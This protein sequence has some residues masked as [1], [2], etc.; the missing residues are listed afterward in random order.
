[1][2][3]AFTAA[4]ASFVILPLSLQSLPRQHQA[5][6]TRRSDGLLSAVSLPCV[7]RAR[8]IVCSDANSDAFE[9]ARAIE[10]SK[11]VTDEEALRESRIAFALLF[12]VGSGNEGIYSRRLPTEDG[13]GLDLVVCF[14]DVDDA[15]R[16]SDMLSADDFPA[17]SPHE[18]ETQA[19][20]EFCQEGGHVLGLVR[21]GTLVVPPQATVPEFEWSPGASEEGLQEIPSERKEELDAAR[22]QLEALLQQSDADDTPEPPK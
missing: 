6:L 1:M 18:V 11:F 3:S 17:A 13:S 15:Q 16:Y 21:C 10:H 14:E 19:L 20:L 7:C 4:V 9:K 22:S 8:Q 12:N 2:M 5:A